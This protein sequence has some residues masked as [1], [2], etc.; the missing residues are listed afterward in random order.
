M[1]TLIPDATEIMKQCVRLIAGLGM[2]LACLFAHAQNLNGAVDAQLA[3]IGGQP[4]AMLLS[5]DSPDVLGNGR[6]NEICTRPLICPP[7]C[8]LAD[9][10][11]IGV[12]VLSTDTATRYIVNRESSH[13]SE[14]VTQVRRGLFFSIGYES[15]QRPASHFEDGHDSDIWRASG[16]LD[17]SFG[18]KW[19]L[20]IA[21]DA[22]WQDG[23]FANGGDFERDTVGL[24]GFGTYW[25]GESASLDFQ[26]GYSSQSNERT[27]IARS[28]DLG[29]H[30]FSAAGTPMADFKADQALVSVHYS[31]D[32]AWKNYT[33]GPRFGYDWNR[34]YFDTYS[35]VDGSGL[36]LTFHNDT[37]SSSQFSGGLAGSAAF[38]SNFGAVLLGGSILYKHEA[39][40]DQRDVEISFVED[41]RARRFSYQTE[42]PD[43]NFVE[44]LATTTFVLPNGLQLF[45]VYR[46]IS[47]HKFL[48]V[49]A[50]TLGFRK[51]F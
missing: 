31:G 17:W 26:V 49:N 39:D 13:E 23:A 25:I 24:K 1:R 40:Q 37:A 15:A 14:S 9:P 11:A 2:T 16:G 21:A 33:L 12:G 28:E 10:G 29:S 20:G 41:T 46:G 18:N 7:V 34:T 47:A 5:G 38:S 6:L 4:C 3:E 35:E 19:T 30:P 8:A 45:I 42:K 22:M 44:F 27:R 36:A 43:R 50:G 51:E 48:N 32:W